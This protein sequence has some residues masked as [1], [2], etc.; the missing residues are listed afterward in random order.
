MAIQD[1]FKEFKVIETIISYFRDKHKAIR[2]LMIYLSKKLRKKN[3]TMLPKMLEI[4]KDKVPT[5]KNRL[6]SSFMIF[7]KVFKEF[8]SIML[9]KFELYLRPYQM[10]IIL[11]RFM[12]QMAP[13]F[14]LNLH[15]AQSHVT[16]LAKFTFSFISNPCLHSVLQHSFIT[17]FSLY[18]SMITTFTEKY[19]DCSFGFLI[20]KLGGANYSIAYFQQE[21]PPVEEFAYDYLCMKAVVG[22]DNLFV[23]FYMNGNKKVYLYERN[24]VMRARRV[25]IKHVVTSS[26]VDKK[27]FNILKKFPNFEEI[28]YCLR[29]SG[30]RIENQFQYLL[31]EKQDVDFRLLFERINHTVKQWDYIVAKNIP[32][33]ILSVKKTPTC[34]EED[35]YKLTHI[36]VHADM[37]KLRVLKDDS[38]DFRRIFPSYINGEK[39]E[40]YIATARGEVIISDFS[41]IEEIQNL[42]VLKVYKKLPKRIKKFFCRYELSTPKGLSCLFI[43]M[44]DISSVD[45]YPTDKKHNLDGIIDYVKTIRFF[46]V[47]SHKSINPFPMPGPTALL[48]DLN[49]KYN[50]DLT[51]DLRKK[52][53]EIYM[54]D[55]PILRD[56]E[57]PQRWNEKLVLSVCSMLNLYNIHHLEISNI[58]VFQGKMLEYFHMRIIESQMNFWTCKLGIF[59]YFI[60]MKKRRR[61]VFLK[62]KPPFRNIGDDLY[63][64]L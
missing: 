34:E 33:W 28:Y 44:S 27:V 3:W 15:I 54:L 13:N 2:Y 5:M 43:K 60:R 51:L 55:D 32:F 14:T 12:N 30:R 39:E 59:T 1:I 45:L 25:K 6:N 23:D 18:P 38:E 10:D 58:P 40:P 52:K 29:G 49:P 31:R 4:W 57:M 16:T 35:Q 61:E 11:E 8:P 21:I 17:Y 41:C 9:Y 19:P 53:V 64:E 37:L 47:N 50:I 46:F 20:R 62:L 56:Q 63:L 48:Y 26:K 7:E 36:Q 24:D 22:Y 42:K